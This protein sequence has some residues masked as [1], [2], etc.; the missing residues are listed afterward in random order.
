MTKYPTTGVLTANVIDL[1]WLADNWYGEKEDVHVEEQWTA[2]AG[3]AMMGMF[4][5]AQPTGDA[6]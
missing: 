4:R 3:N 2:P 6:Q 1:S 5:L